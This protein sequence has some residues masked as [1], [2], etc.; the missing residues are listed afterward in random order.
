[1]AWTADENDKL[2]T[3]MQKYPVLW[4]TDRPNYGK[5]QHRDTALKKLASV[6]FPGFFYAYTLG[7]KYARRNI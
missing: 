4:T 6:L 2:I 1:M 7:M 3:L 5:R